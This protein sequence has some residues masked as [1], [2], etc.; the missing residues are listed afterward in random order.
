[1]KPRTNTKSLYIVRKTYTV[2][3]KMKM[4]Q[5]FFFS[6]SLY[7]Y[8]YIPM[9]PAVSPA[10]K[11]CS[12]YAF[13]ILPTRT[14]QRGHTD[15]TRV[16]STTKQPVTLALTRSGLSLGHGEG[17]CCPHRRQHLDPLDQSWNA[18][19]TRMHLQCVS[20]EES[21]TYIVKKKKKNVAMKTTTS[22]FSASLYR[23]CPSAVP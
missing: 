23:C 12:A 2:A 16:P 5:L 3:M 22:F 17:S 14:P 7:L 1:M 10:C 4:A 19:R 15:R 8:I 11:R 9:V 20:P 18:Q 6:A 21:A 13:D